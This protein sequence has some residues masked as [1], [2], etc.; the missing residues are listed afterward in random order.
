MLRSKIY[1]VI[2]INVARD[3]QPPEFTNIPAEGASMSENIAEG[4]DVYTVQA[5][6][7]DRR[8]GGFEIKGEMG[9]CSKV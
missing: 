2:M 8:V 1:A 9:Y 6:D 3:E 7:L 5:E 4:S